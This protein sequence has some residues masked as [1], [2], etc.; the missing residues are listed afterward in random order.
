MSGNLRSSPAGLADDPQGTAEWER[1][2]KAAAGKYSDFQREEKI[3]EGMARMG[4]LD[5]DLNP[6]SRKNGLYAFRKERDHW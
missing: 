2:W 5:F 6:C 1:C 4:Q 3:G